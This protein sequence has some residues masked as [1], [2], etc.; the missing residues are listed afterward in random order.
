MRES[1]AFTN[2]A[3]QNFQLA[4]FKDGVI[5]S[6]STIPFVEISDSPSLDVRLP[7]T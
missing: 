2:C 4:S 7:R 1:Q 3:C 5:I 6:L